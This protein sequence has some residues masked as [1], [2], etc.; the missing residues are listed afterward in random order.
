MLAAAHAGFM[1]RFENLVDKDQTLPDAERQVR[2]ARLLRS[3]MLALALRSA[4]ARRSR[5]THVE[6]RRSN[7]DPS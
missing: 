3:H 5:A 2:A 7:A 6:T 4:E 1:R